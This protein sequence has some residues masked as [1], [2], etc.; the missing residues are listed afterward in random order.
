VNELFHQAPLN[1]PERQ[2]RWALPEPN[3][4]F[5][6]SS[7]TVLHDEVIPLTMPEVYM[8]IEW[9]D[10]TTD[11]VYSPSSVIRDFF[12]KGETLAVA[13]FNERV[14]EALEEA[15]RRVR[16]VYGMGC[17]AATKEIER[18]HAAAEKRDD[19]ASVTILE[20]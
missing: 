11:Q 4:T 3:N 7:C 14:T 16:E 17:T 15:S 2:S 19:E 10:E 6:A 18:L 1:F 9:S 20:V 8:Q 13:E 12:S 5:W